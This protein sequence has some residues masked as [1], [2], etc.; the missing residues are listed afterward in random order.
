MKDS[1]RKAID[2]G[3]LGQLA[4]RFLGQIAKHAPPIQARLRGQILSARDRMLFSQLS[5]KFKAL[6]LF[7]DNRARGYSFEFA[8]QQTRRELKCGENS[9]RRWVTACRQGGGIAALLQDKRRGNS[10]RKPKS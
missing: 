4:D 6:A 7:D 3:E 2:L 9:L 10:G 1:T 5:K 8:L